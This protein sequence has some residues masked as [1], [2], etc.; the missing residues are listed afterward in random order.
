MRDYSAGKVRDGF[1]QKEIGDRKTY[2][3][4]NAVRLMRPLSP[5]P[6]E[7]NDRRYR[8]EGKQKIKR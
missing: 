6:E 8:K 7:G 5:P 1:E 2:N 4:A 3:N